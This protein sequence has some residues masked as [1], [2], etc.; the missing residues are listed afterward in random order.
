MPKCH[1]PQATWT[2]DRGTRRLSQTQ[3][4]AL[5]ICWSRQWRHSGC[6]SD[7]YMGL[8]RGPGRQISPEWAPISHASGWGRRESKGEGEPLECA[9]RCASEASGTRSGGELRTAKSCSCWPRP[10]SPGVWLRPHCC[11]RSLCGY[12][13]ACRASSPRRS[14]ASCGRRRPHQEF[15]EI[16]PPAMILRVALVSPRSA[17]GAHA[18]FYGS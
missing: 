16:A 8:S 5:G 1:F 14:P 13:R 2:L 15:R 11:R 4:C 10:R 17:D 7:G 3:P 12:R 9:R 6:L 18:D